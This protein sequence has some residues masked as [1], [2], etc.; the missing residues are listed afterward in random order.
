VNPATKQRTVILLKHLLTILMW[1]VIV[2]VF[3]AALRMI[4]NTYPPPKLGE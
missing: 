3:I 2:G 1:A 4:V